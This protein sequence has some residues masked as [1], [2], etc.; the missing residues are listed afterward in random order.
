[1]RLFDLHCDTLYRAFTEQST[2]F[3]DEFHISFN[4]SSGISPYIQC[5]AIWIPDE[6]RGKDAVA[7]FDGCAAKLKEQLEAS[8]IVWCRS[9]DDIEFV[10]KNHRQ[11]I[12]LTVESGAA[13][14]GDLH[15]ITELYDIGVRM[16]TLTWN[17]SNELGDGIGITENGGLSEFGR[18][19]VHEMEKTGKV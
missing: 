18:M 6:Y 8:S 12:I 3:N 2:L 19:A 15:R 5:L 17:G 9:A 10:S 7:L 11:G 13:L 1:M 14:A 16:M 4:K